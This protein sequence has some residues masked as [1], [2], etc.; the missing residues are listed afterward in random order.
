MVLQNK[1]LEFMMEEELILTFFF[2][3]S[4]RRYIGELLGVLAYRELYFPP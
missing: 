4:Y 1:F 3:L 2:M